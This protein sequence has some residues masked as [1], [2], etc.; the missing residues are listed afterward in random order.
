MSVVGWGCCCSPWVQLG[1]LML[2]AR[3]PAHA[4]AHALA[5]PPLHALARTH[6]HTHART[7]ARPRTHTRT[8]ARPCAHARTHARPCTH[9]RT[10][11]R[12]RMHARPRTHTRPCT[13]A[14]MHLPCCLNCSNSFL[15][16][17]CVSFHC[18]GCFGMDTNSR[19]SSAAD[20]AMDHSQGGHE[21]TLSWFSRFQAY[22]NLAT[23]SIFP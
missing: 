18:A 2:Y 14:R 4:R 11:A 19:M 12:P 5:R 6:T 20:S 23:L 17:R 9:A 16:M 13:H 7:H 21:L 10:H 22:P 15:F 3:T 1:S 8:P